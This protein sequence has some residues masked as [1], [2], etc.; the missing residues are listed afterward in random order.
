[1]T[2]THR[3]LKQEAVEKRF[4]EDLFYR[5]SAVTLHVPPLRDRRDDIPLLAGEFLKIFSK[6]FKKNLSWSDSALEAMIRHDWPGNIRELQNVIESAAIFAETNPIEARYIQL[7]AAASSE[8][9]GGLA[10]QKIRAEIEAIKSEM[11]SE[12]GN[13]TR[14]AEHLGL[15]RRGLQLKLKRFEIDPRDYRRT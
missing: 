11:S 12:N 9:E 6:K 3:D 10:G 1:M 7:P 15:T 13:V 4:R 14:A 5:L 8:K 2:A